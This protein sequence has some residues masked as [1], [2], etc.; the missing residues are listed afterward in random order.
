MEQ[1]EKLQ[2]EKNILEQQYMVYMYIY[3]LLRT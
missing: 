1:L 2:N 3:A